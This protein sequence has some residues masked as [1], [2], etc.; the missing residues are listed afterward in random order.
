MEKEEMIAINHET[1]NRYG[2]ELLTRRKIPTC[3][4]SVITDSFIEADLRGV[5]THGMMRF[6]TSIKRMDL[7][8]TASTNQVEIIKENDVFT[9][10][11]GG[12]YYG[13][14]AGA[15]AMGKAIE[16]ARRNTV[17]LSSVK[18]NG[19][20]G[21]CA[22]YAMMASAQDMVGVAITNGAAVMAPTGGK[23][24]MIGN[25][26][27]AFSVPAGSHRPFVLDIAL[28]QVSASRLLL[29]MA[30]KEKIPYGWALDQNGNPT[31]DPEKGYYKS[32]GMLLPI[33]DYKGYGLSMIMDIMA[34]VLS[35]AAFGGNMTTLLNFD[36]K[37]PPNTGHFFMAINI[38]DLMDLGEFKQRIDCLFDQVKGCPKADGVEEIFVPGEIE[39]NTR[40]TRLAEGIPL[41][42]ATIQELNEYGAAVGLPPLYAI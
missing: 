28:S 17:G 4:A 5:A 42:H 9:K 8:L 31:D 7:G 18:N 25:N 41:H 29:Y 3:D 22:Y 12:N 37:T 21:A 30:N 16:K 23:Q 33:G 15:L 6:C 24:A 38:A 27:F 26:P 2:M 10:V 20:F 14:V 40:E 11:D 1:L 34:G 35:G 32:H 39:H 13:P 19:H 36:D